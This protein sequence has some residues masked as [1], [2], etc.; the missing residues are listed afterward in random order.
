MISRIIEQSLVEQIQTQIDENERF[1]IV[2]HVGPDGDAIGSSLAMR[3]FLVALG[4]Q[5]TVAVPNAFPSFLRWMPAAD[6]ILIYENNKE[7][8]DKKLE[9][10]DVIFVM[11]LNERRRMNILANAVVDF[12]TAPKIMIDHHLH[13]DE[14]AKIIVSHP[15]IASTS[16]LVFHLIC[17]M[18]NFSDIDLA[19]AECIYTGMMTD[20]GNFSYNS[21]SK[22]IYQI[23]SALLE[24][25][26]D[27]D[28]IY[29]SVYENYSEN[30]MRLTGYATYRKMKL[31]PEY[32]TA[33]IWLTR[34]DLEQFQYTPGD[35]EGLVNLPM[36]IEG[37]IFS[38]FMR[39]ESDKIKLSF[40]SQGSFPCNIYAQEVF[41]GGGHLNASG[42]ESY[43]GMNKTIQRF[44][45]SLPKYAEMLE[46]SV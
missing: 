29:R 20:T 2:S 31:Y 13:P 15:K 44:E 14:F 8:V 21:L 4:K 38:V 5:A 40:R 34:K 19:C 43:K 18:G 36:S 1:V 42:G 37:I 33:L 6:E 26:I 12:A 11:D 9:E 3:H 27:K 24:I 23:I 7:L 41:R 16:E 22:D 35:A 25:G 46:Q 45:D 30:R 28:K 32:H 17:Q 10:A 39:E